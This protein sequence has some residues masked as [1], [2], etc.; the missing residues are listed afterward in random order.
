MSMTISAGIGRIA[1]SFLEPV[2][3]PQAR[4]INCKIPHNM[5]L[6]IKHKYALLILEV[7]EYPA[8]SSLGRCAMKL[9]GIFGV[10]QVDM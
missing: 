8:E 6:T 2:L 10:W 4:I 3:I 5:I 9:H 7:S 1:N